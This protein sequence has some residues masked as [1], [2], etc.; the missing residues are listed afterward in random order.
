MGEAGLHLR[1][2]PCPVQVA[3][4]AF[5]PGTKARVTSPLPSPQTQSTH[6]PKGP[7]REEAD[8]LPGIRLLP[9]YYSQRILNHAA[10]SLTS[11]LAVADKVP[12]GSRGLGLCVWG[13]GFER[14]GGEGV[15]VRP[16]WWGVM[17][18]RGCCPITAARG[19]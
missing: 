11:L 18:A 9:D 4:R 6:P 10:R 8:A 16:R 2:P 13:L 15:G 1:R 14:A 19:S 17:S 12:D 3:P 7:G 5:N